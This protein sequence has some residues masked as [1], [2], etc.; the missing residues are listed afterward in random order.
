MSADILTIVYEFAQMYPND[1]VIHKPRFALVSKRM[2]VIHRQYLLRCKPYSAR[3]QRHLYNGGVVP[4]SIF[5]CYKIHRPDKLLYDVV[6]LEH[7]ETTK[8]LVTGLGLNVNSFDY[9]AVKAA[10]EWCSNV[11]MMKFLLKT[12]KRRGNSLNIIDSLVEDAAFTY[13]EDVLEYLL[14]IGADVHYNNDMALIFAC[15][16]KNGDTSMNILL[17]RG[18]NIN[19]RNGEPLKTAVHYSF[20]DR[21]EYL[22]SRGANVP[23]YGGEAM[24]AA[25]KTENVAIMQLLLDNG[26]N[27]HTR[28][29]DRSMHEAIKKGNIE[30]VRLLLSRGAAVTYETIGFAIM[31]NKEDIL[32]LLTNAR[33]SR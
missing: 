15:T 10:A 4:L 16:Q 3:L 28:D 5:E 2:S 12:L 14:K 6:R 18:A 20:Y 9:S 33:D 7:L 21:V 11:Q 24:I 1:N 8:L 29:G 17:N 32:A 13:N 27:I 22:I 23:L 30:M 19:A 26:A 31:E 25:A